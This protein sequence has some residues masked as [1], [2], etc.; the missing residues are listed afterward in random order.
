LKTHGGS[1][2]VF[3]RHEEDASKPVTPAVTALRQR[4]LDAGLDGV[5]AYRRFATQVVETKLA[6]LDFFVQAKRA[7]KRIVAYGAAA[8]GNTLLNYCGIRAEMIDFTVDRSPHKQGLL[9]PGTRIPIRHPDAILE[10]K[11]DYVFILPWN[12]KDEIV[13]QMAAVRS[14]GGQFVVPI[15]TIRIF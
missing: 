6:V 8:K 13:E 9:L 7:G 1:L 5:A 10:A 4:E 14:W 2:R 12:L 11:P 15:P 3:A